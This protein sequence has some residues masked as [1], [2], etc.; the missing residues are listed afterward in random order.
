LAGGK[1]RGWEDERL[2]SWEV[3][4]LRSWEERKFA[5]NEIYRIN[6]I[7]QST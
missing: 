5:I 6:L 7:N 4:R 3:K 2:G 1:L